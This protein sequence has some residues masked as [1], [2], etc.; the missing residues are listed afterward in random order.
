MQSFA[1]DA[2]A[3]DIRAM[4]SSVPEV[5]NP[6]SEKPKRSVAFAQGRTNLR[7]VRAREIA[8]GRRIFVRQLSAN[9]AAAAT[10]EVPLR[11]TAERNLSNRWK[12]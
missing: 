5:S 11:R 12:I 2:H 9:L 3:R 10:Y 7:E 1:E 8:E 4:A 6:P